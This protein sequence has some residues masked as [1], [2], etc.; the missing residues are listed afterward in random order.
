MF[1]G[2]S[3]MDTKQLVSIIVI[4]DVFRQ[5]KIIRLLESMR[6]QLDMY[7]T[8]ILLL[9]E[10][11]IPV[12]APT[13]PIPVRYITI[14][15][16]QGI[17]FNRNQGLDHAR[18]DFIVY[19][20]DDCWV[21]ENWLKSL[22]EPLLQDASLMAVT[23]GTKIPPSNFLG[24]CIS[25]LGFPGG[26][27]L[28]FD[29][30][31]KVS[32]GG[33]TNHL[34]VGNCALHREIFSKVGV[35][36]ETMKN[37][38]EDAEFSVRLERAHLPIKYV[39]EGYAFHEART[40]WNDFVRWQLR[41]GKANYHFKK[42]VGGVGS[43]VSL[44]VWSAKNIVRHNI[45]NWRLPVILSLQGSSLVLQHIGYIQEKRKNERSQT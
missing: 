22:I 12:A 5:E 45:F 44:R 19:I 35:F 1:G 30:V 28:G 3:T 34:A 39:P 42:K 38:A 27:S 8:E 37:G 7:P 16:K 9:H 15:E 11:N 33:F 6:P 20:D 18:G 41:R 40:T 31:W 23:S 4:F 32:K 2:N 29:K 25:A 43:F 36:D 10:S 17:P 21:Q 14:A 13:L 26:G 24:D